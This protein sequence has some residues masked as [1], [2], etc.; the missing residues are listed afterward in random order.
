MIFHAA[1]GQIPC[2]TGGCVE[3][4]CHICSAMSEQ[5]PPDVAPSQNRLRIEEEEKNMLTHPQTNIQPTVGN[6]QQ[7]INHTSPSRCFAVSGVDTT[8]Q[9]SFTSLDV[10]LLPFKK[11]EPEGADM[12]R[13]RHVIFPIPPPL[14]SSKLPRLP[15]RPPL[16]RSNI[17]SYPILSP[18]SQDQSNY[19]ISS[20]SC[21][22]LHGGVSIPR[23]VADKSSDPNSGP[24]RAS[25]TV[26]S[27]SRK[28]ALR[29]QLMELVQK[30]HAEKVELEGL[31]TQFLAISKTKEFIESKYL[32]DVDNSSE[33]DHTMTQSPSKSQSLGPEREGHG[34]RND[35][36]QCCHSSDD[37][38]PFIDDDNGVVV[39][40]GGRD[41]KPEIYSSFWQHQPVD[42]VK[43]S[44]SLPQDNL[45]HPSTL[46]STSH[47]TTSAP[48]ISDTMAPSPFTIR[49][50]QP[51]SQPET[52]LGLEW[53]HTFA[54][55]CGYHPSLTPSQQSHSTSVSSSLPP[56][57]ANKTSSE[58]QKSLWALPS[59]RIPL[60][61]SHLD[62]IHAFLCANYI[63]G[64][65]FC[66]NYDQETLR[67]WLDCGC[68]R[69]AESLPDLRLSNCSNRED[70]EIDCSNEL[71]TEETHAKGLN[72]RDRSP[73]GLNGCGYRT[74]LIA[75]RK[76]H[77]QHGKDDQSRTSKGGLVG[78]VAGILT[79]IMPTSAFIDP[80]TAYPSPRYSTTTTTPSSL[81]SSSPI[82]VVEVNFLC[83][84]HEH[85]GLGLAPSLI[86]E[87]M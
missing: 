40:S 56:P 87:V 5:S 74:V 51:A 35:V 24:V 44:P 62:E 59:V 73:N 75:L 34:G 22:S 79:H 2:G 29:S 43:S 26:T 21:S 64:K 63:R 25:T 47:P 9:S 31:K 36:C 32:V 49:P 8:L 57:G 42:R 71:N 27:E 10:K 46:K 53:D 85:R 69:V 84:S 54:V 15:R 38:D 30:Q 48:S 70:V 55:P 17:T 81:P 78:F 23:H 12:S 20:K 50:T 45:P 65:R 28:A 37:D 77:C 76:E 18:F 41:T 11:A 66:L 39:D 83:I 6:T 80:H 3:I 68:P 52:I 60:A 67:W 14:N 61:T 72:A 1:D 7:R 33:I 86:K 4:S 82:P 13:R 16:P 58:E 19:T